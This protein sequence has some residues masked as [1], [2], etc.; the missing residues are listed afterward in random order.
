MQVGVDEVEVEFQVRIADLV[1]ALP[2]ITWVRRAQRDDASDESKGVERVEVF[3][4]VVGK[5]I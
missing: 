1:P 3:A 4:D 5:T 2:S